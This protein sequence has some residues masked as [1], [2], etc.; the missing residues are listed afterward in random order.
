[1]CEKKPFLVGCGNKINGRECGHKWVAAYLPINMTSLGK[2]LKNICCP[3]CGGS[4]K[5]IFVSK[6]KS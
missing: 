5:Y 4:S 1:M 3:M 2:I 6:E